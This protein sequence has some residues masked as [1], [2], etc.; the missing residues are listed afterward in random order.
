MPRNIL[1]L[2]IYL[3]YA[4]MATYVSNMIHIAKREQ[5]KSLCCV[6]GAGE[7]FQDIWAYMR[8]GSFL[9]VCL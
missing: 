5:M 4:H 7:F 1:A 8:F 9:S 6:L 3:L 2:E